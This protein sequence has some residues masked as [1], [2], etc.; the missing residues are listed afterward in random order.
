MKYSATATLLALVP[1][2]ALAACQDN[3]TTP[4]PP[5]VE[6]FEDGDVPSELAEPEGDALVTRTTNDGMIRAYGRGRIL[7][8][9]AVVWR[10]AKIPEGAAARCNTSTQTFTRDNEPDHEFSFRVHYYVDDI[11]NVEWDDQWRGDVVIGTS[12]APELAMLKHQ[13]VSGSDFI[14]LSEGTVQLLATG[15]PD[16]TEIRFVEHLDAIA[17]SVDEVTGGMT[18]HFDA[19]VALTRDQPI[20]PCR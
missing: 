3:V 7:A 16:A 1:A 18:D 15:D 11:L 10:A 4:F 17:G 14:Y 6:P 13:K 5:G 12:D 19:L 20:P 2:L 8:P 9:P